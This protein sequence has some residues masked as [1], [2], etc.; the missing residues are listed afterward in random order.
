MKHVAIRH[1]HQEAAVAADL[2]AEGTR[3]E[4]ESRRR[5]QAQEKAEARRRQ[6]GL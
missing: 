5:Q 1:L 6:A 2:D 3:E 4:T